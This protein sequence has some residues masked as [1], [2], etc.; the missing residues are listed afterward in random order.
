MSIP[1]DR[2]S[3]KKDPDKVLDFLEHI[4]LENQ[5][6]KEENQ[7]LRSHL[8]HLERELAKYTSPHIPSSKQLYPKKSKKRGKPSGLPIKTKE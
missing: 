8:H 1:F 7:E 5:Q 4:Y 3:M 6:I 2:E